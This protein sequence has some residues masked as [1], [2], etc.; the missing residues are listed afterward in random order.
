MTEVKL[1]PFPFPPGAELGRHLFFFV[2]GVRRRPRFTFFISA[3]RG[4]S[5][6]SVVLSKM[7]LLSSGPPIPFYSRHPIDFLYRWTAISFLLSS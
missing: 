1:Q 7:A 2:W 6:R 3:V 5:E 4:L